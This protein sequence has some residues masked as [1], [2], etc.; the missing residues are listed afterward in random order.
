MVVFALALMSAAVF[1]IV[2]SI[3]SGGM[4][5][6]IAL[7][8]SVASISGLIKDNSLSCNSVRGY[9]FREQYLV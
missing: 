7:K 3:T 5:V 2:C 1:P 8:T 4:T 9:D 6:S